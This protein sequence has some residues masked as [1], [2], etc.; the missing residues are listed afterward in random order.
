MGFEAIEANYT[1]F[2]LTHVFDRFGMTEKQSGDYLEH[3][4][5]ENAQ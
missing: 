5:P 4:Q 3:F 1:D 2:V